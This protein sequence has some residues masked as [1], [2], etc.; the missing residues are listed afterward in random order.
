MR[1]FPL[2]VQPT[3]NGTFTVSGPIHVSDYRNYFIGLTFSG[4]DVVGAATL[5]CSITADFA[6]FWTVT[7]SSQNVTASGD[8]YWNE[9]NVNY[10]YVRIRWTNTSGTGNISADVSMAEPFLQRGA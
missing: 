5:E 8:I 1:L 10:N 9:S 3:S 6:R 7:N 2:F 4:S